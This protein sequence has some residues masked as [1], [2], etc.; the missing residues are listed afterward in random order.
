MGSSDSKPNEDK[1]TA[2]SIALSPAP[3]SGGRR[4]SSKLARGRGK[5]MRGGNYGDMI[6]SPTGPGGGGKK[7]A[8]KG[9][10]KTMRGGQYSKIMAGGMHKGKRHNKS[11]GSRRNKSKSISKSRSRRHH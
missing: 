2:S 9:R 11:K 10:G 3:V 6:F 4:R 8:N 7:R 1:S 5:T